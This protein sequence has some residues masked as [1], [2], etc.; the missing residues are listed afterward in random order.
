[1]K[2]IIQIYLVLISTNTFFNMQLTN[3]KPLTPFE[4]QVYFGWLGAAI[5]LGGTVCY[6]LVQRY[7]GY[8]LPL[9]EQIKRK[10][11]LLTHP[12]YS[13]PICQKNLAIVIA[14][15]EAKLQKEQEE[16]KKQK[17]E[18]QN[19]DE[20]ET[21]STL[22]QTLEMR[23]EKNNLAEELKKQHEQAGSHNFFRQSEVIRN[24]NYNLNGR[25]SGH[26]NYF[27]YNVFV[28]MGRNIREA[29]EKMRKNY[30][31]KFNN[32]AQQSKEKNID[33]TLWY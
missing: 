19:M 2:K 24:Q 1:M 15:L 18:N 23:P 32:C 28:N 9:E 3:K 27:N 33:M 7:Q 11:E 31:N 20:Q 6:G 13:E 14:K 5:F 12:A 10:K 16:A 4:S 30:Q 25:L 8:S 29:Y 21:S 26:G 17:V 22:S